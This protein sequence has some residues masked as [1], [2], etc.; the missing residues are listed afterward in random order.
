MSAAKDIR[1]IVR[2]RYAAAATRSSAGEHEGSSVA[3]SCCGTAEASCCAAASVGTTDEQGAE[4]FGGELYDPD[5]AAGAPEAALA[6]SLGCGVP[7]AVADLH[8]GELSSISVPALV[9]TSSSLLAGLPLAA[10]RS[11]WT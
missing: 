6:A 1:E 9:P 4:V 2:Q 11:G 8:P 5:A 7:T 3:G 10:G